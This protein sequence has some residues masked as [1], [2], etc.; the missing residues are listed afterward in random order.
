MAK[1]YYCK[2]CKKSITFQKNDTLKCKDCS[3]IFGNS[4]SGGLQINMRTTLSGTTQM[5]FS[6]TTVEESIGRMNS[7]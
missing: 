6:N 3:T 7:R 4:N 5:E 2:T 1:V